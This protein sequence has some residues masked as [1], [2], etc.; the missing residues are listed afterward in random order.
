MEERR[1]IKRSIKEKVNRTPQNPGVYLLKNK[2]QKIVY[3]G[4]AK[5]LRNRLRSHFNPGTKE[6]PRH[7]LMMNQ[8]KDFEI[9]T[10]DNEIEALILEAN[11]IKEHYPKY[12]V[13]LRDDKSFPYIRVTNEYYPRIFITRK[14]VR[15]GSKYFGPYTE[16]GSVRQ[17]MRAVRKI[18]PVRTCNRRITD[19][20]VNKKKHKLCLNYHINRCLGPCEGL[21]SQEDYL[22]MVDQIIDFIRGKNRR[23]L[24]DLKLKMNRAAENQ[25]Y[26]NAAEIRDKIRAISKFQAKQ[27]VVDESFSDRDIVSVAI[28]GKDSCGMIFNVREGKLINRQHFY[29]NIQKGTG[30][31]E[32]LS[33]FLRQYYLKT[34]F[35][36]EEILIPLNLNDSTQ[37]EK[38]LIKKRGK[39]IK[40][41]CPK[42]G[43]KADLIKMC[44]RN[45]ELLL[46]ELQ[47]LK[48]KRKDQI[49]KSVILLQKDLSLNLP[50]RRIEAF[51]ISN[52]SGHDS[53]ASVVVFENGRPNKNEYRQYKIKSV[54]GPDDYRSIA[55][56]IRRRMIRLE[57]EK[58]SFP[59]LILVDGGKGQLSA[60]CAVLR[61]IKHEKQQIIGLAKRL[62]QVYLPGL[63][64]PQNIPKHSSSMHLLQRIR[65]EAHRFAVRYHK[66]IRKKRTFHSKLDKIP[67]VGEKRR[68]A[69]LKH[70]GSIQQIREVTAEKISEAVKGVSLETAKQIT[71][72]LKQE[73]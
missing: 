49:A 43:R 65:D 46:R 51:D 61:E 28:E 67:G 59:D 4:K 41:V 18:F 44:N 9:L 54:S 7:K 34:D 73:D 60:A 62:E 10:T 22:W 14:I 55:E 56:V 66:K 30:E 57:K 45:A 52:L 20:I 27:K 53:A 42:R 25:R 11:L 17:L 70:F 58:K 40:L 29:L 64:H 72:F 39:K 71:A 48:K 33:A 35:I 13:N 21:I 63:A 32:T 5:S 2:N 36:P 26:E 50:P 24:S 8:V 19:E 12:N 15:D 1:K 6:E 69:L 23:L 16:V 47:I 68:N 37:I 3:V 31:D 38:W